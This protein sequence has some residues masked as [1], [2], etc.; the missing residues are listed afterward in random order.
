M[1]RPGGS[2]TD[3]GPGFSPSSPLEIT[4][5]DCGRSLRLETAV[6]VVTC[7]HCRRE[8]DIT[9]AGDGV[10]LVG[11]AGGGRER[12]SGSGPP[13]DDPVLTDLGKWQ[14]GGVFAL[15]V[16]T[17]GAVLIGLAVVRDLS[18]YG[19][20]FFT[21]AQNL[22]IPSVLGALAL[23]VMAAGTG[24]LYSVRK[25]RKRY[26]AFIQNKM[27]DRPRRDA[28]RPVAGPDVRGRNG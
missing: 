22:I 25:E 16:G 28:G 1:N 3:S 11:A 4:C 7:P 24:V 5:P 15:V 8:L 12:Q 9:L 19:P 14:T 18:T 26:D 13:P 21:R 6:D 20:L 23:A 27:A 17:A 2:V 10:V